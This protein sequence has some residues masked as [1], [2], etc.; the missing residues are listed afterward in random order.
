MNFQ[1]TKPISLQTNSAVK[2]IINY[3]SNE[4]EVEEKS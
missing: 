2:E 3:E 4:Y 1:E